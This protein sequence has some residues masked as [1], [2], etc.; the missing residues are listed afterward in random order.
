[1]KITKRQLKRIIREEYSRLKRRGLIRETR[2]PWMQNKR[3]GPLPWTE[4]EFSKVPQGERDAYMDWQWGDDEDDDSLRGDEGEEYNQER[5]DRMIIFLDDLMME[6]PELENDGDEVYHIL[7]G[8]FSDASE[9]EIAEA[10]AS[11]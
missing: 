7:N 4:A 1:M 11:F 5:V 9:E 6:D 10:M 2:Y 8:E 3:G